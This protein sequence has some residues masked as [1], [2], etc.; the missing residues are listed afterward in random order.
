MM[1][2]KTLS[3]VCREAARVIQR[4]GFCKGAYGT[5]HGPKCAIG[6]MRVARFGTSLRM[7]DASELTLDNLFHAAR[8]RSGRSGLV[9]FNDAD[10]TRKHDVVELLQDMAVVAAR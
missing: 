3:K 8:P 9:E 2:K 10:R 1:T 5:T 6:A 4:D 7:L